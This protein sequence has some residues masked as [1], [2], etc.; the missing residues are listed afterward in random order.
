M[1]LKYLALCLATVSCT[2]TFCLLW[3]ETTPIFNGT[4]K[5]VE[6]LKEHN[7]SGGCPLLS[8]ECMFGEGYH[9]TVDCDSSKEHSSKFLSIEKIIASLV[10]WFMPRKSEQYQVTRTFEKQFT[11]FG[12][13]NWL[14]IRSNEKNRLF[15]LRNA[16]FEKPGIT[17]TENYL[18]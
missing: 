11:C 8:K 14:G 18:L 15:S 6:Y 17:Q 4:D 1:K 10:S 5:V 13:L 2:Q 12:L 3:H 16:L 7:I 9:V